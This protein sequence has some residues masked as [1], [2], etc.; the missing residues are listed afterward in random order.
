M[1]V[2]WSESFQSAMKYS[3]LQFLSSS[4]AVCFLH[5]LSTYLVNAW[6]GETLQFPQN[7]VLK[8]FQMS[9]HVFLITQEHCN[10]FRVCRQGLPAIIAAQVPVLH[11][12]TWHCDHSKFVTS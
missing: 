11:S 3:I 7:V 6:L 1:R 12:K 8:S 9:R 4:C 2:H 5:S 10:G